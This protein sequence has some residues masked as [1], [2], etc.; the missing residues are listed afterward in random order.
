[1]KDLVP[2]RSNPPKPE[3][4]DRCSFFKITERLAWRSVAAFVTC[5]VGVS[6]GS[7]VEGASCRNT[8][9][10]ACTSAVAICSCWQSKTHKE[11]SGTSLLYG[12]HGIQADLRAAT[13][14]GQ[15]PHPLSKHRS[16][17]L[18]HALL[19]ATCH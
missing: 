16:L 4:D 3:T 15:Q 12:L 8:E 9:A 14:W 13:G 6:K 18:A 10:E 1:M 7:W 5:L 19:R 17:P 2:E 11:S